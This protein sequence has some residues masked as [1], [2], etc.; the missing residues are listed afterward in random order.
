M[1]DP[2]IAMRDLKI[3]RI[4]ATRR[5]GALTVLTLR[6]IEKIRAGR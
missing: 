2:Q 6:A 3:D 4:R 1:P 5:F